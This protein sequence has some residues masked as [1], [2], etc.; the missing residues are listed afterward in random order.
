[1]FEALGYEVKGLDRKQYAFLTI[2]GLTR[3]EYRHL[4]KDEVAELRRLVKLT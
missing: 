2:R 3:G 1:L 4:T